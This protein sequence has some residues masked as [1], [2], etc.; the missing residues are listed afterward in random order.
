MGKNTMMRK[1][2]RGQI[3]RNANLEKLLPHVYENVGFVFTKEDLSSVRDKLLENKVGF[4][5]LKNKK[6]RHFSFGKTRLL[7][8]LVPLPLLP[9]M[10]LSQ[11]KLQV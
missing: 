8:Q 11:L 2:I 6:T 7:L 4:L 9:S 1:T 3:S 5:H 10:S